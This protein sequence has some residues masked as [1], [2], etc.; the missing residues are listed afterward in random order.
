M[1]RQGPSQL[2]PFPMLIPLQLSPQSQI[3]L[4]SC[5]RNID[6]YTTNPLQVEPGCSMLCSAGCTL[7]PSM[8]RTSSA[9]RNTGCKVS[10]ASTGI[11]TCSTKPC[12]ND[13][14]TFLLCDK[15]THL[16]VT[17]LTL[18]TEPCNRQLVL[19]EAVS[20]ASLYCKSCQLA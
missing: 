2:K 5:T 15:L 9:A 3:L 10:T 13:S 14:S 8:H 16:F 18:P 1:G 4:C 6:V 11:H 19:F 7:Q 20:F 17:S 12:A